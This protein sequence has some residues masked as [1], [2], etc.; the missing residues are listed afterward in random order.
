[1]VNYNILVDINKKYSNKTDK[2]IDLVK[3]INNDDL[4]VLCD[5]FY[6][7]HS[8]ISLYKR[9]KNKI[10]INEDI[11]KKLSI[12]F[13]FE[14]YVFLE[15]NNSI[16]CSKSYNENDLYSN[17][18]KDKLIKKLC[19]MFPYDGNVEKSDVDIFV[20]KMIGRIRNTNEKDKWKIMNR[21]KY[22]LILNKN[23][24]DKDLYMEV[25]IYI[26]IMYLL[27]VESKIDGKVF[28]K[29]HKKEKIT[30]DD[31]ENAE[32]ILSII[33]EKPVEIRNIEKMILYLYDNIKESNIFD[34]YIE[35]MMSVK[36]KDLI[37]ETKL[38]I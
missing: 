37:C 13:I 3:N 20:E 2:I 8:R 12:K 22:M 23:K 4:K 27:D 7:H 11:L 6:C 17:Y 5:L 26:I 32:D 28:I 30:I 21:I 16:S 31:L 18:I 33:L 10:A 14:L 15:I 1:M 25:K 36:I 19:T 29:L 34:T 35:D 9:L 24:N 38:L